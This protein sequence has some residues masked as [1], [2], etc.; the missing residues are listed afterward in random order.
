MKKYDLK[1][2]FG[3]I[4]TVFAWLTLAFAVVIVITTAFT[5]IDGTNNGKD[6]FGHKILV[7]N[8][9]SMS[10]SSISQSEDIYFNS[11][12][13]I[14]VKNTKNLSS[15]K[16]GDVIAFV[17]YNSESLGKTVTHKIRE[18]RYSSTGE[19]EGFI[20][21]GINTGKNDVVEVKPAHVVG[22][23]VFKVP[24]IGNFFSFLKT[25]RGFYLSIVMPSVILI[26]L[27]SIKIG[28]ILG[29]KEFAREY[30]IYIAT[31]NDAT[32]DITDTLLK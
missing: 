32:S 28:K 25:P 10:R 11:G 5:F 4:L 1:K 29:K 20:T 13:V 8:S 23:Y 2:P 3:I 21:Y 24:V 18:I 9:N 31:P 16:V 30:G 12:D 7:V 19:V 17:S 15:F 14:V 6:I 27:F 26:M 22:K